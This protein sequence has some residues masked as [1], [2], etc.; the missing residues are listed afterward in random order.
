M[1]INEERLKKSTR[2]AVEIWMDSLPSNE[3]LPA[4]EFSEIFQQ[5]MQKQLHGQ[6]RS[7]KQQL[8]RYVAVALV[9]LIVSVV[10]TYTCSY[11][12]ISS[13]SNE[14]TEQMQSLEQQLQENGETLDLLTTQL[15]DLI[16]TIVSLETEGNTSA[17]DL[18]KLKE[19][20]ALLEDSII[21]Q[22]EMLIKIDETIQSLQEQ[23]EA[24]SE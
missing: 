15:G 6:Q 3:E 12:A 13:E 10:G 1:T 2:E 23:L 7:K 22:E 21:S 24:Q 4:S 14:L 18:S 9:T 5:R 16:V 11:A 17:E 8:W 20:Q 19:Q